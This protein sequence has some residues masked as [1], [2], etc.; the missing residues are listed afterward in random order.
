MG[1]DFMA[2]EYH[3]INAGAPPFGNRSIITDP[4]GLMDD[5]YQSVGGDPHPIVTGPDVG[6][7]QFGSFGTMDR[8]STRHG[9]TSPWKHDL[10]VTS[11]SSATQWGVGSA[12]RILARH[13][14][15]CLWETQV[16]GDT[17][18]VTW[19][20]GPCTLPNGR[21]GRYPVCLD[22]TSNLN[23]R[24][25]RVLIQA[26]P[27]ARRPF[28]GGARSEHGHRATRKYAQAMKLAARAQRRSR[29]WL[30]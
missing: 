27:D 26:D 23:F 5:P 7:V 30:V 28:I 2:G 24:Q 13:S 6:F 17:R 14:D 25:R 18:A 11:S 21:G 12:W 16:A 19:A 29:Q 20:R 8:A 1:Y 9:C 22:A 15:R 4:T 10:S 3:N